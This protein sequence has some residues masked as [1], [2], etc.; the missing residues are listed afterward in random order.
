MNRIKKILQQIAIKRLY[1]KIFNFYN[2]VETI[3][4]QELDIK[5]HDKILILAPHADD[6]II[7]CGGILLKYAKQCN[8]LCVTNCKTGNPNKSER[9]SI[10]ERKK[11]FYNVMDFLKVHG[12]FYNTDI[13]SD[14][15]I[16]SYKKFEKLV[17]NY[18]LEE[19]DYICLPIWYDQHADHKTLVKFL[20]KYI[21]EHALILHCRILF[22]EVWSTIA[23]P[24]R[25]LDLTCL[26]K[27]K[28]EL[29]S[30]YK[31]QIAH[32]DYASRIKALN[33]YR[34]M[35]V[36]KKS[37]EVYYEMDFNEFKRLW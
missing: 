35:T 4:P 16:F 27:D 13:D 37:A 32:I 14:G 25:Y 36:D 5:T 18:K 19:Y 21:I 9:E 15:L 24:N 20:H 33:I 1:K 8:V 26:E 28:F 11:E 30:L 31:S 7:G 17:A 34:G 6:E 23:V 29:M 2:A 12:Y 3:Y 22:Y 10:I